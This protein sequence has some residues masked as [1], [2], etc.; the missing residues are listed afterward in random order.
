MKVFNHIDSK[1]LKIQYC[2][3]A[4]PLIDPQHSQ[5]WPNTVGDIKGFIPLSIPE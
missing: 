1:I 4:V 3:E 2:H 5:Q